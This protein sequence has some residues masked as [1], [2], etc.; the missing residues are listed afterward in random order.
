MH[1]RPHL[2]LSSRKIETRGDDQM[3][4]FRDEGLGSTVAPAHQG[5]SCDFTKKVRNA[6]KWPRGHTWD[7]VIS[8]Q[9]GWARRPAIVE[10]VRFP[11]RR[12][13]CRELNGHWSCA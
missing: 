1:P 10:C 2:K 12:L 13:I 8:I 6:A 7:P 4:T 3:V 9:L 5:D 11:R